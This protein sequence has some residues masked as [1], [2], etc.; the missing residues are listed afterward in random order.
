MLV[1]LI[2]KVTFGDIGFAIIILTILVK[3]ILFP[4][5]KK[6]IQSQIYMKKLEPELKKLK[7]DYPNKEEQAKK[8]FELYKKYGVN[9]FSG[10]LV[11]LLQLP[12]IFALYYVF[13]NFKIDS[14]IIYSFIN[15][16]VVMNTNFLGLFDL[17]LN[18]SI[19]LA[20]L[21]GVSQYFQ[22]YLATPKKTIKDVEVVSD[23][24][25]KTFQ[26]ELASSMQLNIRY[27][28]PVFVAFIAYTF[29]AGVALYW[30]VSNIFTIGQ[31][32]YVRDQIAKKENNF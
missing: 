20:L 28:L 3:L 25:K 32:W 23:N 16:P 21:A 7:T 9:P 5:A 6:S 29:S 26:E 24:T 27:V 22:A 18:H 10:C 30:I 1:F 4:L 2:D 13:I 12:V 8:Q 17:S 31:E 11:V 19:F 14:S 15:V